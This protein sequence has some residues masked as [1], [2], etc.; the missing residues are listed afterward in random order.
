MAKQKRHYLKIVVMI[1]PV[2]KTLQMFKNHP[3]KRTRKK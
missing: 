1:L 2:L 3:N